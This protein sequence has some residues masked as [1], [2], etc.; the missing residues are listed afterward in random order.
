[1]KKP[2]LPG[3]EAF[4]LVEITLALGVAAFALTAIVGLLSLTLKSSKSAM[5][6][7]LVAEMTGDL[8]NTLRKQD[9]TNISKATN[10][11]FDIS[12]K[13]LNPLDSSGLIEALP[14]SSAVSQGAVYE[15]RPA[16]V[17]DANTL[18]PDGSANLWRVTLNF[19]WPAG[20]NSTQN[21]KSIH[22]DIARY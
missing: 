10:V 2:R 7:T 5:D 3:I 17:A 20:A 14:V 13:R 1:V 12:G 18:S 4:S 15:C 22:A 9:F 21:Q 8:V 11:F 16:V 19:R 6:D